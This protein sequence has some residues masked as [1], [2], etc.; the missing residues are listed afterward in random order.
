MCPEVVRAKRSSTPEQPVSV[1]SGRGGV[2]PAE[3]KAGDGESMISISASVGLEEGGE[4]RAHRDIYGE[5]SRPERR[6]DRGPGLGVNN[7]L[8]SCS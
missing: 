7:A 6:A 1:V 2:F 5:V 3:M 8:Q 4:N